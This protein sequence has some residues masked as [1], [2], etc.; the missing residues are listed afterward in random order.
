M[1]TAFPIPNL[2]AS[3]QQLLADFICSP[4]AMR[5]DRLLG[6]I[7]DFHTRAAARSERSAAVAALADLRAEMGEDECWPWERPIF[8]IADGIAT[9]H[10]AGAFVKGVDDFTCWWWGLMSTDRLQAAL[11]ALQADARVRAVILRLN[12]PGGVSTGMPETADQI[13]ALDAVKP[14]FAFTSDMACSNGYRVAVAARAFLATRSAVVA[15]VGTYIAL[16]NYADYLKELGIRLE[17]Y[18]DGA[19]KAIGLYGKETTEAEAAFLQ[20]S[21]ARSGAIFKDFVRARRPDAKDESLQG[22]WFDA[23]QAQS[24][25]LVDLIMPDEATLRAEIRAGLV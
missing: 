16:Y 12:S 7:R 17:L 18:R 25:G 5:G 20:E 4:V 10:V 11:A 23:E 21:V 24:L 1:P 15:N 19:L 3:A 14:V 13:M 6:T 2:D 9:V 22:Q 8:E